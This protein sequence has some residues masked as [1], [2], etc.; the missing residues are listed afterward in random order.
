MLTLRLKVNK[1]EVIW[2]IPI[3]AV[4]VYLIYY[5]INAVEITK[6]CLVYCSTFSNSYAWKIDG[7]L[8]GALF[9]D[10]SK[11]YCSC[12]Y[13]YSDFLLANATIAELENGGGY[14]SQNNILS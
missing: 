12:Y 11:M 10:K 1:I 13:P 3:V 4:L 2:S 9:L 8:F 14:H 7:D 6:E 5:V